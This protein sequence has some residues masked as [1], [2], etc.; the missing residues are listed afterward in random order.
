MK[1]FFLT[2]LALILPPVAVYAKAGVQWQLFLNIFFCLA[3]YIPAIIH[4]IWFVR[5]QQDA[6][7]EPEEFDGLAPFGQDDVVK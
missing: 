1:K 4:A 6:F 2:L 3:F 5:R 7:I